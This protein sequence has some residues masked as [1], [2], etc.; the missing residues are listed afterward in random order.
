MVDVNVQPFEIE[1]RT[2]HG[3]L[4]RA[5]V[6]LPRDHAGPCPVLLGASPYQKSLRRLPPHWVFPFIEY[7]PMQLYLDEGYAYVA[8]DVPGT[9]RSEGTWDFVSRAEGEAIH[10][11]IEHVAEQDWSTGDVGMIGMSYYC[12]S[13]WNTARTRPP[14]LKC[15]GAYDGAT[16]MY[17]DWMYHG[18]MP[19]EMFLDAW[20]FGAVLTQ[21][22]WEG[23]D[24]RGGGRGELV[25]DILTHSLDDEWQRRRS[26]FWELDQ[27]DIPV[28][29][30]GVWGKS[31][32]HLR[33]NFTG[34]ERVRGP[35]QLVVTE[36]DSFAGAQTQ[37]SDAEFHRSELLPWYDHHLKG[38]RNGVMDRP[39]VRVFVQGEGKYREAT[40]WPPDDVKTATFFLSGE[41]SGVVKSL[42]D[43]SLF[44]APPQAT[45]S[46]TSWSYPDPQWMA[47]VTTF[48]EKGVPDHVARVNTFTSAPFDR[49]R[50]FTGQGV[51]VLHASS[52]QTDM[53]VIVKLTLLSGKGEAI[54]PIKVSQ[55]WLRASH[56]AEDADLT[57][58]MRPFHAHAEVEPI[59]PGKAYEL[60]IELIPMSFLVRKGERIRLEISNTDSMITDA[61]MTHFYGQKVGTDTYHHDA[62]HPSCLRLH[63]RPRVQL[64]DSQ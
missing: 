50:E 12:W 35:R 25:Y 60:R 58:D 45:D 16:D 52:D 1:M 30:I 2:R 44:D 56:R 11:M 8:M 24:I 32:L 42:N 59:T 18:G 53:D 63:E 46:A 13:Q 34:F 27:I 6:Y 3:D 61:P 9:G 4:V 57:S 38:V 29:S 40:T 22:L 23:R 55:G 19:T 49:D 37:Y 17:R 31:S 51:L 43:G 26:P 7:G 5:D 39:A 54:K 64:G 33:G 21:H 20:L 28:L 15:L 10:D 47:G 14:S 62:V 41:Q 36:P 48:D